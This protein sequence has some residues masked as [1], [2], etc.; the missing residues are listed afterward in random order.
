M[1]IQVVS[2]AVKASKSAMRKAINISAINSAEAPQICAERHSQ[3][4]I[5][6]FLTSVAARNFPGMVWNPI[7]IS[8]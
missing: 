1:K 3:A 4:L 7:G 5:E 6:A 2:G 8:R